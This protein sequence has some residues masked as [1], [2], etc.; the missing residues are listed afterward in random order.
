MS[1]LTALALSIAVLGGSV[2]AF[3]ALGPFGTGDGDAKL[4]VWEGFIAWACYF[5]TVADNA[6][7]QKASLVC[8][9]VQSLQVLP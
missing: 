8:L 5:H 9:T 4:L 2:R 7:L 1:K 3:L 6:A